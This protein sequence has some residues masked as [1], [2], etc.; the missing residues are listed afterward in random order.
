MALHVRAAVMHSAFESIRSLR[1]SQ[2]AP[3]SQRAPL[4]ALLQCDLQ[5]SNQ[6]RRRGLVV[7]SLDCKLRQL[8]L[9]LA[10]DSRIARCVA[11]VELALGAQ[12]G[13]GKVA[14]GRGGGGEVRQSERLGVAVARLHGEAR[15]ELVRLRGGRVVPKLGVAEAGVGVRDED[16]SGVGDLG[17]LPVEPEGDAQQHVRLLRAARARRERQ[18]VVDDAEGV[19][20]LRLTLEIVDAT[21]DLQ[22]LP[23]INNRLGLLLVVAGRQDVRD[24][25]VRGALDA[26]A[27]G[28]LARVREEDVVFQD[29]RVHDVDDARS[30]ANRWRV[31]HVQGLA[32]RRCGARRGIV[33]V[34]DRR[35]GVAPG[36]ASVVVEGSCS[37]PVLEWNGFVRR[38]VEVRDFK[39]RSM[40][41]RS[42]RRRRR[43]IVAAVEVVAGQSRSER[44]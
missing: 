13:R 42:K 3:Q 22:K 14:R 7:T 17:V 28:A 5:R 32:G 35:G 40:R 19:E 10:C 12:A 27:A 33:R 37:T 30:R 15:G 2:L 31:G 29:E 20:R 11:D 1:D 43:T 44:R 39:R 18:L 41:E 4:I 24:L 9:R 36:A 34:V 26:G 16:A 21:A 38:Y 23:Q 25:E 8:L 6:V